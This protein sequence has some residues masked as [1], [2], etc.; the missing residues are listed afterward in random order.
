MSGDGG[1]IPRVK[2]GWGRSGSGRRWGRSL[3]VVFLMLSLA[4]AGFGALEAFRAQR[5]HQETAT[6]LLEDYGEFAAWSYERSSW[7]LLRQS[8]DNHLAIAY[9][10]TQFARGLAT[11]ECLMQIL[12][13]G[14]SADSCGCVFE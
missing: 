14:A 7:E 4:V 12:D 6:A 13:P 3:P 5:S 8:I 1:R 9:S 2:V 10:N 11:E